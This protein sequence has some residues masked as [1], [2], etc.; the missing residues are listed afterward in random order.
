M[1]GKDEEKW[2]NG[3]IKVEIDELALTEMSAS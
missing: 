1:T 2:I 3:R